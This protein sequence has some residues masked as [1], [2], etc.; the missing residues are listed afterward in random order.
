MQQAGKIGKENEF[1]EGER[2]NFGPAGS[3]VRSSESVVSRLRG[4][5]RCHYNA[6]EPEGCP[7]V[8]V[9]IFAEVVD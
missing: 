4:N 1:N 8:P 6:E 5:E 7:R 3:V 2:L 9:S